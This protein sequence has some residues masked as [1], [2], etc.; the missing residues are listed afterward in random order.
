VKL[1]PAERD[2]LDALLNQELLADGERY[3]LQPGMQVAGES[4]S[5]HAASPNIYCRR[6][7]RPSTKRRASA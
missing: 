7:R 2:Y 6:C 5:A 4:P 3:R 1:T